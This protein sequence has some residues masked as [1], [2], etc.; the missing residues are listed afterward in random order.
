M[1]GTVR[2]DPIK[3]REEKDKLGRRMLIYRGADKKTYDKAKYN[4]ERRKRGRWTN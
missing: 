3:P 4:V 1:G 2:L